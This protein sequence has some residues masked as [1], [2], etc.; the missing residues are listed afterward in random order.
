MDNINLSD[1]RLCRLCLKKSNGIVSIF[2][3][4]DVRDGENLGSRGEQFTVA[5]MIAELSTVQCVWRAM[6]S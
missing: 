4:V 5:E 6:Q 2:A 3:T 1:E